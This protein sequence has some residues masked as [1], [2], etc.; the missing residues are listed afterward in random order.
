LSALAS[1][2]GPRAIGIVF[3]AGK[4]AELEYPF[5]HFRRALGS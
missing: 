1:L 2:S 3:N 4:L 5:M